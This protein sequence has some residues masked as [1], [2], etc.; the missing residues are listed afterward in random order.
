MG[1]LLITAEVAI[2]YW[3]FIRYL[4]WSSNDGGPQWTSDTLQILSNS[5]VNCA[6]KNTADRIGLAFGTMFTFV[7]RGTG[8]KMRVLFSIKLRLP[9]TQDFAI[10]RHF[11][12]QPLSAARKCDADALIRMRLRLQHVH[13]HYRRSDAA[14]LNCP[15]CR[16]ALVSC[17]DLS[18]HCQSEVISS[19]ASALSDVC[20]LKC[21]L[22]LRQDVCRAHTTDIYS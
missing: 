1:R 21:A 17:S 16:I 6:E 11:D 18:E 8:P 3:G 14:V 20:R 7:R 5:R 15:F 12:T 2:L 13:R 10:F 22:S 19:S 4:H 9:E